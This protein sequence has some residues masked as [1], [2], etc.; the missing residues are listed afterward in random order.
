MSSDSPPKSTS[1]GAGRATAAGIEY[2]ARAA[3]YFCV[4][5][6]AENNVS[7][8]WNLA[9][10]ETFE[11]IEAETKNQVDDLLIR[12]ST[13]RQIFINAKH[14]LVNSTNK[15]SDFAKAIDQL[16]KQFLQNAKANL[17]DDKLVLVTSSKSSD[18]IKTHFYNLLF[19]ARN[20]PGQALT[21]IT[22]NDEERKVL[23]TVKNH[24]NI[25]W[26]EETG[27]AATDAQIKELLESVWLEILDV[28]AGGKDEQIAETWLN[29]LILNDNKGAAAW[30]Q[31]TAFCLT[32][33]SSGGGTNRS[34]LQSTLLQLG[35]QLKNTK[36]FQED[37]EKLKSSTKR[38]FQTLRD[39]SIIKV[40]QKEIKIE[41]P[42]KNALLS[43]SESDSIVV[44]GE[45]GSG[46]S[47]VLYDFVDVLL[48]QKR[49]V[50][51]LA[52]DKIESNSKTVFHQ[53]LR[54]EHDFHEIL[55]NWVG[56]K[57]A[58]LVI[59]ALDASRDP[60]KGRFINNL[61]EDVLQNNK[62][63]RVIT[64]I[65]KFDLRYNKKLQSLFGGRLTNEY[66]SPEFPHLQH[67]NIPKL[68]TEEWI[69][70]PQQHFDFGTLFMQAS[71]ELRELLFIPFNLRLLGE[72]LGEGISIG[73]LSPIRTQIELL[74]R[75]WRERV[76]G[77]DFG[78]DARESILTK[79][80]G[81]MVVKRQMQLNRQELVDTATGNILNRYSDKVKK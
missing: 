35:L 60:E 1:S 40:G 51:F 28:D 42:V 17:R 62:R 26:K 19:R 10:D 16:V 64:S 55:E 53:E 65:R 49:D 18:P 54:L 58:Y 24:I 3:A 46:K 32:L 29:S 38:V 69:Q 14:K 70:I 77:S 27:A 23:E 31:L 44:I 2:Q 79:A 39:L 13:G 73:E 5:I 15:T 68:T 59:D 66:G 61:I 33:I 81:L 30:N 80:V 25:F 50:I 78:G 47:G 45:P 20:S 76:I 8:T 7:S 41:R 43:A 4:K 22:R 12:T 36:S 74:E 63:W 34:N 21:E 48:K 37:I 57:P 71:D 72:L 56:E 11:V 6:L 67:I 9:G 75:Y 52:V